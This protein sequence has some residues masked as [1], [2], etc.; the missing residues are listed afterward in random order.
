ML[1]F[2]LPQKELSYLLHELQAH[3]G[4][5]VV[6]PDLLTP[7]VSNIMTEL[8]TATRFGHKHPKRAHI[9]GVLDTILELS[10]QVTAVNLL[11]WLRRFLCY[12]MLGT[13]GKLKQAFISRDRFSESKISKAEKMYEDGLVRSFADAYI[14]EIKRR[15]D[16][17]GLF[18]RELLIGN[19]ASY[20]GGGSVTMRSGLEWLFLMSAAKPDLQGRV[21][22][23][24]DAV[25]EQKG[26]TGSN[27]V[28]WMDRA[29]MPSTQAFMWETMRC[30]PVNPLGLMRRTE[31][32]FCTEA[33]GQ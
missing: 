22:A 4:T 16:K 29:R 17:N 23:E 31:E 6:P 12:F 5:P 28:S 9:D 7:S 27:R 11:P 20:F 32:E 18:T 3:E 15:G 2:L 10:I 8:L 26:P 14:A 25:I 21:Q 33:S 24:I 19:V 30:K 1:L 13:Y